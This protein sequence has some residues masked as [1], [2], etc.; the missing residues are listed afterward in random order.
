MAWLSTHIRSAQVI[1]RPST[2]SPSLVSSGC[3]SSV[4]WATQAK[5]Q[6]SSSF[7]PVSFKKS[8]ACLRDQLPTGRPFPNVAETNIL[9]A[10]REFGPRFGTRNGSPSKLLF[11]NG[12]VTRTQA[13]AVWKGLVALGLVRLI[14][15]YT[16]FS[17]HGRGNVQVYVSPKLCATPA[18]LDICEACGV[19][20]G[21]AKLHF[22]AGPPK[23]PVIVK[24]TAT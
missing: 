24:A 19:K 22:T 23:D 18:L 2:G 9:T 12:P 15:G 16:R 4:S 3:S 20:A 8:L 6:V 17:A 1:T 11:D 5:G 14:Q 21:T 10:P 13:K 7:A